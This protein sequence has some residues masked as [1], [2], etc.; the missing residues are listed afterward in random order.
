LPTVSRL[1]LF[2]YEDN[3]W[4]K[5]MSQAL[6]ERRSQFSRTLRM[7]GPTVQTD[8]DRAKAAL[9]VV[10]HAVPTK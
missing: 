1:Q 10:R 5:K 8:E 4:R 2:N 9:A 7:P 6:A 3:E